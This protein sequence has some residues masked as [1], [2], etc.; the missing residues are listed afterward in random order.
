MEA[1]NPGPVRPCEVCGLA[2]GTYEPAVFV[3]GDEVIHSSRAAQP[4]LAGKPGCRL[5][6]KDCFA[7]SGVGSHLRLVQD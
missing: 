1:L 7:E 5:A 4:G 6:H 2:V 3:F